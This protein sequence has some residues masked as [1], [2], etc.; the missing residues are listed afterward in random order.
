MGERKSLVSTITDRAETSFLV[1]VGPI[2]KENFADWC[3]H[4]IKTAEVWL[5]E[6]NA[7]DLSVT[8]AAVEK[9][10]EWQKEMNAK[11]SK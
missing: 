2:T 10:I 11:W 4:W 7:E 5:N 9:I 6:L 3:E 8:A 1:E